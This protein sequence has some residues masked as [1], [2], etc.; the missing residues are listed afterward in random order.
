VPESK[1]LL[2]RNLVPLTAGA[3][4]LSISNLATVDF[5]T[6][7]LIGFRFL[8][9]AAATAFS[10]HYAVQGRTGAIQGSEFAI[11]GRI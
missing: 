1:G 11:C 4:V 5:L 10:E 7:L 9:T 8:D 6:R 2:L 3:A